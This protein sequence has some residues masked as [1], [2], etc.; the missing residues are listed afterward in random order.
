MNKRGAE[1]TISTLV[2][3]VLAIIVLVVIA[4]GFGTG[5]GNLWGKIS[6]Y[7]SPVNVD[8]VKQACSYACTTS[9]KYTYCCTSREVRFSKEADPITAT[10]VSD[11][12]VRPTDCSFTCNYQ[13]DCGDE[14]KCTGETAKKGSCPSGTTE[15]NT[16]VFDKNW[17]IISYN[18]VCCVGTA[19]TIVS[20]C[21]FTDGSA[22][23]TALPCKCETAQCDT[24]N[25]KCT[26]TPAVGTTSASG[27]CS[28]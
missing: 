14:V 12:R 24:A 8:S 26:I 4:L 23:N 18:Y 22:A 27:A 20:A 16:K 15:D 28:A 2:V 10:C 9:G 3:I 11:D 6:G 1:M 19:A 13:N 21:A 5:W 25:P 17:G 7:F